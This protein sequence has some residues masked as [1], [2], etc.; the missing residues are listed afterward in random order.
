[1]T[2]NDRVRIRDVAA[3]AGVSVGTVSNVLNGRDT[4]R[5][6]NLER[7]RRA[8]A[9]LGFV[10]NSNAR[11]LRI[12]GGDAIG[13]VVLNV[14][15]PFFAEVAHVTEAI[16]EEAGSTII[17]GSSDQDPDREDHYVDLFERARVKG[18]LVAPVS[19][20]TPRLRQLQHRGT[21]T[22]LLDDQI[23]TD[24]FCCVALDGAAGGEQA[25]R[26]L[27][28]IGRRDIAMIGGPAHHVAER[29]RGAKTA[30][31]KAPGT[32]LT[33]YES[34]NLDVREGR[35]TAAEYIVKLPPRERP[36]AIFAANDLL[37]VGILQELV[38]AG[39]DIPRD[40]AIIGYDNIDFAETAI[41]PLSTIAQPR[42]LLAN[43]AIRLLIDEVDEQL[44]HTHERR[45][46]EPELVTR[47]STMGS[48]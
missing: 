38:M 4:V 26:H 13:L 24:Q 19:G 30:A 11:Q 8:I 31:A 40:I 20:I 25:V 6:E 2:M 10:P 37:A 43:E 44:G 15:N 28:E 21:P 35:R 48:R 3:H 32:R 9:E 16:A 36:D 34:V 33:F 23:E 22:I 29:L 41:V 14:A 47:T 42:E 12:G 5:P 18:L 7:V 17:M 46:L 1:M 39:I 45:L 27:V